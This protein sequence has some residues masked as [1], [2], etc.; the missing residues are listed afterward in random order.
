MTTKREAEL[1]GH[2][3]HSMTEREYQCFMAWMSNG[4]DGALW[5]YLRPRKRIGMIAS[6]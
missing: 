2:I 6:S 3:I 1:V 4:C 5:E